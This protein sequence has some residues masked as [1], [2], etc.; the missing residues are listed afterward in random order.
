[1]NARELSKA[2]TKAKEAVVSAE[3][4]VGAI[5]QRIADVEAELASPMPD[6]NL[7]VTRAAEH[8][9]LQDDLMDAL[10]AW[11]LAVSQQEELELGSVQRAGV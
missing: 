3:A 7:M 9:R 1:M 5:E 4:K 10:G 6:V 11:E 8:T 2:R